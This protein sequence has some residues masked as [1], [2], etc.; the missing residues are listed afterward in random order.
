MDL[1][2]LIYYFIKYLFRIDI[3]KFNILANPLYIQTITLSDELF[4]GNYCK[5]K[6]F[7]NEKI[8]F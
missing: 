1:L 5:R 3:L 6:D 4:V 7:I 2:T 8:I